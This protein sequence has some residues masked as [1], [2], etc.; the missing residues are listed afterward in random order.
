M[1]VD[2]GAQLENQTILID[3]AQLAAAGGRS[4]NVIIQVKRLIL[5]YFSGLPFLA[6]VVSLSTT[7]HPKHLGALFEIV[8]KDRKMAYN[9]PRLN[10][11]TKIA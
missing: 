4:G 7:M 9:N 2:D 6:P 1:L 11:K 5:K 10:S 3:E 8:G